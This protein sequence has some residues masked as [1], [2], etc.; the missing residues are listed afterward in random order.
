VVIPARIKNDVVD[1]WKKR[2]DGKIVERRRQSHQREPGKVRPESRH[3]GAQSLT[4]ETNAYANCHDAGV[5]AKQRY[6]SVISE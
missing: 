5:D 4:L 1:K 3:E 6:P 2:R